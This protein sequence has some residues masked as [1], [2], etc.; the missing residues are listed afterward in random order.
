MFTAF[1]IM[2]RRCCW[3]VTWVTGRQHR[4]CIIPQAAN[5]VCAPEDG[6]NYRPKHVE[7]IRIIK[8]PLLLQLVGS[9]CYRSPK[10]Y[11]SGNM[12]Q[13][14]QF[15]TSYPYRLRIPRWILMI[16]CTHLGLAVCVITCDTRTSGWACSSS[17]RTCLYIQNTSLVVPMC[18]LLPI[19]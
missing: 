5:T 2:H 16:R 17:G 18:M 7:L 11:D 13:S 12:H 8:K 1:G 10:L 4:R 6:R 19:Q 3:T 15:A 14:T 9:L